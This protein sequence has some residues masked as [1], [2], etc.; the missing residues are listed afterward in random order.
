[1]SGILLHVAA[2]MENIQQVVWMIQQLF[3]MKLSDADAEA[4]SNNKN[5]KT[6]STTLMEKFNS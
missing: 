1:M 2:K 3:L 6:V 5:A 4:E